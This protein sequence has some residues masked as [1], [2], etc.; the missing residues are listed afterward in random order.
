MRTSSTTM[1]LEW[2]F[3]RENRKKK[4]FTARRIFFP[5]FPTLYSFLRIFR[6]DAKARTN[7]KSPHSPDSLYLFS[8]II[9]RCAFLKTHF[10]EKYFLHLS[11]LF[12]LYIFFLSCSAAFRFSLFSSLRILFSSP[13]SCE[14]T[15]FEWMNDYNTLAS[16]VMRKRGTRNKRRTNY[17]R[18][19]AKKKFFF[20]GNLSMEQTEVEEKGKIRRENPTSGKFK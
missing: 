5:H 20:G 18:Q 13:F 8:I 9:L 1:M 4:A 7:R 16:V 14:P 6:D 3:E 11:H 2:V 19:R 15:K 10:T 17:E 12:R